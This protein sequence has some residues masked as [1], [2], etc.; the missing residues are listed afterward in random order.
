MKTRL[1]LFLLLCITTIC[2]VAQTR[3][4]QFTYDNAGNRTGRAIVLASAPKSRGYANDS[5]KTE[6]YTDT[7]AEYQF[8]VY[9]NPTQGELKIE[10]RGF[11]EGANYHL[12]IANASGKVVINH[13]TQD[14]PTVANLTE[15]PAGIYILR[16]Q[17][18]DYTKEFKIIRL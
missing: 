1:P 17:Y 14:N 3:S 6:I 18:K 15:C 10:L 11:P 2:G 8:L 7:F 13:T 16:I 4:V 9:P 5:V 12:L